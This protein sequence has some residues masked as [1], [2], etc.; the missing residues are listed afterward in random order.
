MIIAKRL[1]STIA[2][3]ISLAHCVLIVF[4][5]V[6]NEDSPWTIYDT[7]LGNFGKIYTEPFLSQNWHLFSPNPGFE[8]TYF[9]T[10]YRVAGQWGEWHSPYRKI[11]EA[12][13]KYRVTSHSKLMYILDSLGSQLVN[14]YS[15]IRDRMTKSQPYLT[16]EQHEAILEE[17]TRSE[18]SENIRRYVIDSYQGDLE[19]VSAL[20]FKIQR[21]RPPS[22]TD[23]AK[24]NNEHEIIAELLFPPMEVEYSDAQ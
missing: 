9:L 11:E 12:H 7:E 1:I 24:G 3:L 19:S 14:R 4:Y 23:R 8:P 21:T 20:Q 2:V 15:N 18:H 6:A 5:T 13:L 10:R 16:D 17:L 22:Y